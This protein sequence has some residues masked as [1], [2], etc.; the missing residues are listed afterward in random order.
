M[1]DL[2]NVA[3]NEFRA[4][5]ASP[6]AYLFLGLFAAACLFVFFWAEA[7]FARN[8]ADLE[9]LFDWLP[10]LLIFLIA[11]L[12][13]RSWSEERRAGTLENLLTSPIS[14]WQLVLGK[15]L[16]AFGLL[17]VALVLT[18]P[19]PFTVGLLGPLD[20][21]PVIGGYLA[22]LFLGSSYIAIGLFTS[23][24]TDNPIVA[25]IITV[26][27]CGLLYLIGSSLITSLSGYRFG[28]FLQL[29]GTGS[30][31]DSITRGV[32]DLR[33]IYYYLSLT[34]VFL[35][36]NVYTLEKLRWTGNP[37]SPS[38]RRWKAGTALLVVNL[39]A[40]NLW[41]HPM[42]AVRMDLTENRLYTLSGV[43]KQQLGNLREPLR[44]KGYF[45]EKTHPLLAPLVP[46]L[47]SLLE[48]YAARGG[49]NVRVEFVDP[50]KNREAEARAARRYGVKPVPFQTASRY[51]SAIVNSY[52]D[53][54][55]AYGDDYERLGFRDLIEVK[56]A[57]ES[58][59]AVALNN[60]EY[61]ITRTIDRLVRNYRSGGDSFAMVE[62][63]VTLNAWV[64]PAGQLPDDLK[65]FRKDLESVITALENKGGDNFTAN[66]RNPQ[67][68]EGQLARRL[69]EDYGFSPMLS[70]LLDPQPFWFHLMLESGDNR[71]QIPLPATLDQSSLEKAIEEGMQQLVPGTLKTVALATPPGNRFRGGDYRSLRAALEENVRVVDADL[72]KGK[73]PAG[74]NLLMVLNPAELS[75]KALFAMD[76]FLMRGGRVVVAAS[77]YDITLQQGLS[78]RKQ[79]TGLKAWLAHHGITLEQSLVLDPR[80][81]ALPVPRT[82]NVGG[83][84]FQEIQMVPYPF[85]PDLRGDQLNRNHPITANLRDMIVSWPSPMGVDSQKTDGLN[86]ARLLTTSAGSWT[87]NSADILPDFQRF[88][89][90]GFAEPD[91]RQSELIAVALSGRFQSWFSD[92]DSPLLDQAAPDE[93]ADA[94]KKG[95][96]TT[97]KS[98]DPQNVTLAS[99]VIRTSPESARLLV[100]S[101]GSFASDTMLDLVSQSLGTVYNS[102]VTFMQNAVDWSLEDPALLA[103]RGQ[104]RYARTLEPLTRQQ[105]L[106]WEYANYGLALA[107]LILIALWRKQV[108]SG[109]RRRY[110][111]ILAEVS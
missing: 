96:D 67:A 7:F 31:F 48:E 34:G 66:I 49:G 111:T 99:S 107:G 102:P 94:P 88:P 17:C 4:W 13:M 21:G 70:S 37:A 87:N 1:T 108:R 29:L 25:L 85:F 56:A 46:R 100:I 103:L 12:T 63:P 44:I 76:Q 11:A 53:V 8:I 16:A 110:Q 23:S 69:A 75:E 41:L 38:H 58:D 82:R 51:E 42:D 60:P 32:L 39:L 97:A 72:S 79:K 3:R 80:N 86:V 65:A 28:Q 43:T 81:A 92:K 18:L 55:I 74:T 78:A 77:P 101:S 40:A 84:T 30:R 15:F 45:S 73:V 57:H 5:F 14:L 20:T 106:A 83:L 33:D 22:T 95:G 61:E 24:R 105:Q 50:T 36:L 89:E 19:L 27:I 52:F 71:V 10:L 93:K 35:A 64:S 47:Q 98:S 26:V 2:L 104:S 9:P 91:A 90:T 59:L 68:G 6:A 62:D 54:V 109:D